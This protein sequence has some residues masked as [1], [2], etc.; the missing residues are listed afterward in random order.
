MKAYKVTFTDII[1][2]KDEESAYDSL[3]NYLRSV[4]DF[5]DVTAFDFTE[6]VKLE[7]PTTEILER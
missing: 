3:L 6:L 7:P 2:A 4:V 1:Q 5:E